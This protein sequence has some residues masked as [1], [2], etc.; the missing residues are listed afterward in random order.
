MCETK[1]VGFELKTVS[2]LMKRHAEKSSTL[3]D[4][5]KL[6]GMHSWVIGYLYRNRDKK[7]IFQRDIETEFSIRRST[8]TG[9][10]QLMEKNGLIVRESVSYDARLKR[11]VLT[12]KAIALHEMIEK[13]IIEFETQLVKGLTEEEINSFL[14]ILQRM[15]KNIK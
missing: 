5:N 1:K 7:E 4:A 12:P 11:L 3:R 6:T 8:V 2:N 10:L 13:E 9:I 15:K 14:S